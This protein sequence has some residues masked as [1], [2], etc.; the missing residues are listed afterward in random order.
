MTNDRTNDASGR[1]DSRGERVPTPTAAERLLTVREVASFL[2]IHE[3]TIYRWIRSR[4]LPC[5]RVGTRLRFQPG[6]VLRWV[7]A[8]REG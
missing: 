8:R 4:R 3:K 6:D 2:G 1:G 7:S 5:V